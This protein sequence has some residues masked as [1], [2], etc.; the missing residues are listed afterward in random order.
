MNNKHFLSAVL[1]STFLTFTASGAH[2]APASKNAEPLT[3]S[4]TPD[5]AAT[6]GTAWRFQPAASGGD[7]KKLRWRITNPP[8][9]ASFDSSTGRLAGTPAQDHTG[10]FSRVTI[11]ASQG[12]TTATLPEFSITVHARQGTTGTAEVS[13]TAPTQRTDGAPIGQLAGYRVL[14][15]TASGKYDQFARIDNPGITQ[16]L[17]EHLAPGTWYFAV[18]AITTDTME[19]APSTEVSKTNGG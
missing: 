13:W 6:V 3:V 1:L 11:S 12:G 10:T 4:G 15:G 17:V 16:Y 14:Y 9:W 2:A 18:T 5:S 7:G 19:S 8:P